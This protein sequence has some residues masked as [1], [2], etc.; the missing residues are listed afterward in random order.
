MLLERSHSLVRGHVIELV[1]GE[2]LGFFGHVDRL[3]VG[4]DLGEGVL[5][6]RV[7][8]DSLGR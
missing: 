7:Q 3:P 8:A 5:R 2:K 1:G 4:T 6:R